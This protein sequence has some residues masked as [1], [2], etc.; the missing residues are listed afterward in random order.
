MHRSSTCLDLV[1]KITH[2]DHVE[3]KITILLLRRRLERGL[4]VVQRDER[5]SLSSANKCP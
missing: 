2:D 5:Y 4:H 3:L 1:Y